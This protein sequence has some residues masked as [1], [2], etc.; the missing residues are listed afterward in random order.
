MTDFPVISTARLEVS[1]FGEQHLTER[2]VSWLNDS[3]VVRY[4]EQRHRRHTLASCRAYWLSFRNTPHHFW[5]LEENVSGLGHIGNINA[6]VDPINRIADV[7]ILVGE[8]DAWGKGYGLEA[9]M[10]VCNGL[11]GPGGMRKVT[12][13]TMACNLAMLK[14]MVKAGMREDGRR[15]RHLLYEKSEMDVVHMALFRDDPTRITDQA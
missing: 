11:L 5:A 2:Y 10:A 9:F 15:I 6:Y 7:G 12:A 14:V 13:G 3:V 8:K 1:P 4:S